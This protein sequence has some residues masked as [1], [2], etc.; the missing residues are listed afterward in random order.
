MS[1]RKYLFFDIDGTLASGVPGKQH[2]P[3][4]TEFALKKTPRR[5]PLLGNCNGPRARDGR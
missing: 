2:V 3:A 4:S 5:G 1:D